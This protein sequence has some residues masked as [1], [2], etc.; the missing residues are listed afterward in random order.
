MLPF[1][2]RFR[3]IPL[4]YQQDNAAIH[5]SKIT[6]IWFNRINVLDCPTRSPDCN[7]M[8]NRIW[9]LLVR[10]VSRNSKQYEIVE[11]TA[12]INK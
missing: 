9:A 1:F 5:R 6:M 11:E 7:S 4:I 3:R 12:L 2:K 8:E 10:C